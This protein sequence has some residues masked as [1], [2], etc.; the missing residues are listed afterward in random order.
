MWAKAY[1]L[2]VVG[3]AGSTPEVEELAYQVGF[4]IAQRNSVLLC[5]GREGVMAAAAR[6]ARDG[7]GIAIG[8]LPGTDRSEANPY[9]HIALPTGLGDARN[10]VIVCAADALIAVSGGYGTLSEVALALKK[11]KPVIALEF[12]FSGIPGVCLAKT[13]YEAVELAIKKIT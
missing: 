10:A 6:G 2:A 3:S 5:G 12:S 8:I 4:A 9:L 1:Y 13:P 7:G 11:R